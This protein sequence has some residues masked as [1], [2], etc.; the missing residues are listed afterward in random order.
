MDTSSKIVREIWKN[1]GMSRSGLAQKMGLDKSTLTN[2]V[3]RLA[4]IGLVRE[5]KGSEANSRGGRR[6]IHLFINKDY[7]CVLGIEAQVESWVAV[8]VDLSGKILG[9]ARGKRH[10]MEGNFSES[11]LATI[12][13]ARERLV[14]R[15]TRLLGIGV[16]TGGLI[17]RKRGIIRYSVPLAIHNDV[18]F[19]N[20]VA[21]RLDVPC[22]VENDANCCA[23][24]ELAFNK[25]SNLRNFI[26]ALVE[27]RRDSVSREGYGG[28]GMGF[29]MVLGGK[30]W[31]GA[32]G[33]AGE[34]RSAFCDGPGPIQVSLPKDLIQRAAESPEALRAVA[35]E[36]ARNLAM[37]VNT[38]DIDRIFVGGDIE[39]ADIDFLGMLRKRLVDNWMYPQLFQVDLSYSSLGSKAVACGAAGMLLDHLISERILLSDGDSGVS[40]AQAAPE[41]ATWRTASA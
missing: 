27:I 33:N 24:G 9:E 4:E 2:H 40:D 35:D 3:G 18:N 25:A 7:G 1:P 19:H 15:G 30:L 11:L 36:F 14:P 22:F 21:S 10:L 26:F 31:S 38:I 6:P 28:M 32:H 17:D 39:N 12:A 23:W 13:D 5:T 8:L 37:L 20:E 16:G 34:F 41:P 29:G